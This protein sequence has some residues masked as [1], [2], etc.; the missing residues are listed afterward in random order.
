MSSRPWLQGVAS[1][2]RS[3]LA[4][5]MPSSTSSS[6]AQSREFPFARYRLQGASFPGSHGGLAVRSWVEATTQQQAA[7]Q[8]QRGWHTR[9][10]TICGQRASLE[11]LNQTKA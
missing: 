11:S 8:H 4:P 9:T 6:G 1:L 10:F 5:P 7:K 2:Q 3:S